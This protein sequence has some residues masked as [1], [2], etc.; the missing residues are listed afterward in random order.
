MCDPLIL[1]V[2]H[3]SPEIRGLDAPADEVLV[4]GLAAEEADATNSVLDRVWIVAQW[5]AIATLVILFLFTGSVL[6]PIK[7]IVLN[8]LSPRGHPRCPR[9]GFPRWSPH[10]AHRRIHSDRHDRHLDS[11]INRGDRVRA[12]DGLRSVHALPAS[13]KS[14]TPARALP[15]L[16]HLACS[17]P[18]A[19]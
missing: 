1:Q 8:V 12:F 7:A 17:A 16:L 2:K 5:L 9:M 13:R 3:S 10:L 6:I 18:D 4:G 11:G 14:M 19:S 15:M